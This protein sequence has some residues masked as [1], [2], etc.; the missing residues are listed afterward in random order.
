MVY[1]DEGKELGDLTRASC[2]LAY[3]HPSLRAGRWSAFESRGLMKVT[4]F[5]RVC[6]LWRHALIT[7]QCE[8]EARQL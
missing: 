2:D 6:N 7:Q 1:R 5:P 4:F 3:E 8:Q